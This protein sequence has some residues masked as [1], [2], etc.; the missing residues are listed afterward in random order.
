MLSIV[1]TPGPDITPRPAPSLLLASLPAVLWLGCPGPH[2]LH[3]PPPWGLC[4]TR[5][6]GRGHRGRVSPG[7]AVGALA[8]ARSG[9]RAQKHLM[10]LQMHGV[11]YERGHRWRQTGPA[12]GRHTQEAAAPLSP[13]GHQSHVDLFRPPRVSRAVSTLHVC[14]GEGGNCPSVRP[15]CRGRPGG[16]PDPRRKDQR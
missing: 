9:P 6:E 16:G 7:W 3:S 15:G 8:G 14:G 13:S 4:W 1:Y 2:R 11:S 12:N 5:W 10:L